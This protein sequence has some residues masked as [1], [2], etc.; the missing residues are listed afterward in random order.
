M[1]SGIEELARASQEQHGRYYALYGSDPVR[2]DGLRE[3]GAYSRQLGQQVRDLRDRV[4]GLQFSTEVIG[5]FAAS[6]RSA[7]GLF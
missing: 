7:P 6:T 5:P 3:I 1:F 2:G 4:I